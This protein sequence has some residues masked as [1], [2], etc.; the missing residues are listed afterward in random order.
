MKG[1]ASM[2]D[3]QIIDLLFCR[4]EQAL[5]VLARQFGPRLLYTAR[6]LLADERD[7]EE[8]VSD[9]YLAIWNTI[10]PHRPDPL[11]G[12]VF[13]TGRNLALKRLRYNTAEK[14]N[15]RYDLSLEELSGCISDSPL[16]AALS[17]RELGQA[18]DRFLDTLPR[19]NRIIFL[20]RYWFGDSVGHIAEDMGYSEN[21]VSVRLNRCRGKLRTYL[22]QE[23]YFHE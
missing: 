4:S 20:R 15:S 2:D 13:K 1:G 18:I 17:A 22:E 23:G 16:D 14:R 3:K 10:P 21:A 8:C 11:S 5:T 7:A 12:F 19:A 6:N 9:T